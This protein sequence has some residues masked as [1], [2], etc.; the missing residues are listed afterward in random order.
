[1]ARPLSTTAVLSLVALFAFCCSLSGA[2]RI[3]ARPINVT[4]LGGDV[5]VLEE[6]PDD[7]WD[8]EY[9]EDEEY[10]LP[11]NTWDI[12]QIYLVQ[13]VEPPPNHIMVPLHFPIRDEDPHSSPSDQPL[14]LINDTLQFDI[15]KCPYPRSLLTQLKSDQ[16][17]PTTALSLTTVNHTATRVTIRWNP[18]EWGMG[19]HIRCYTSKDARQKEPKGPND[20][21]DPRYTYIFVVRPNYHNLQW[22]WD[23]EQGYTSHMI[24]DYVKV[25]N[26]DV[27][28]EK[29]LLLPLFNTSEFASSPLPDNIIWVEEH[30][31]L[32][33]NFVPCYDSR[34]S[35]E[36]FSDP[37]KFGK[38][39]RWQRDE[40]TTLVSWPDVDN[41]SLA[42]Y[43]LDCKNQSTDK[44]YQYRYA[45][46][47]PVFR[48][49]NLGSLR[50]NDDPKANL[51]PYFSYANGVFG[52]FWRLGDHHLKGLYKGQN[53]KLR[54]QVPAGFHVLNLTLLSDV[55]HQNHDMRNG[56]VVRDAGINSSLSYDGTGVTITLY[57]LNETFF[58]LYTLNLT[59]HNG[60]HLASRLYP[61]YIK[62]NITDPFYS[63]MHRNNSL[64]R[65]PVHINPLLDP[66]FDGDLWTGA[67]GSLGRKRKPTTTTTTSTAA[68]RP[69]APPTATVATSSATSTRP[70]ADKQNP[71]A[72]IAAPPSSGDVTV[73]P[74]GFALWG[75]VLAASMAVA[76]F[77]LV[78]LIVFLK[79]KWHV[80]YPDPNTPPHTNLN[81][82]KRA[83]IYL[84]SSQPLVT[85]TSVRDM[86][87]QCETP[88]P[89]FPDYDQV[90]EGP[91][92]HR[93][94]FTLGA[95][96]DSDLSEEEV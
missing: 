22:F 96:P 18:E 27:R 52:Y 20:R 12:P 61:F 17:V 71:E 44:D 7:W 64:Y 31:M 16:R 73:V 88:H 34:M 46:I 13:R 21:W 23:E 70:G 62:P 24:Q 33:A 78:G 38:Y 11:E 69:T 14:P 3:P 87:P 94:M 29:F 75:L 57:Y 80:W 40:E 32:T 72:Q 85:Y 35:V 28:H 5:F 48:N 10:L 82:S 41:S 65:P 25:V 49:N 45:A 19:V 58:G 77:G 2:G 50:L 37:T 4:A 55:D 42:V 54:Y 43:Y 93:Y 89:A 47:R 30:A 15:P 79:N 81:K 59:F 8:E 84:P 92:D 68:P 76:T 86:F 95:S 90:P 1:M 60:S 26:M 83:P 36:D 53:L 66:T 63:E 6:D 51:A 67:T 39:F 91:Y 56:T 9:E 74:T